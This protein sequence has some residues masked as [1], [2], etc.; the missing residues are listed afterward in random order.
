MAIAIT[1]S[2]S[3]R[4]ATTRPVLDKGKV[5]R[6]IMEED[7]AQNR[8]FW[9]R[10]MLQLLPFMSVEKPH[11]RCLLEFHW[12]CMLFGDGWHVMDH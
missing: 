6:V 9:P 2:H 8:S 7:I 10:W 1:D 3:Y 5:A 11:I 12:N 4:L